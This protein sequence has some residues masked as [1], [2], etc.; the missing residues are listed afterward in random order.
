MSYNC[1]NSTIKLIEWAGKLTMNFNFAHPSRRKGEDS[2]NKTDFPRYIKHTRHSLSKFSAY[3]TNFEK[4]K[5]SETTN[6]T[7]AIFLNNILG[8]CPN[9]PSTPVI[10][11]APNFRCLSRPQPPSKQVSI[12]KCSLSTFEHWSTC[13]NQSTCTP[14]VFTKHCGCGKNSVAR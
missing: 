14:V 9:S 5:W 3:Q 1:S 11:K 8:S 10:C 12:R 6:F 4:L 2:N 7:L 13:G